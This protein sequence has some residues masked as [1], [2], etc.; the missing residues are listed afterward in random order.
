MSV[1]EWMQICIDQRNLKEKN[2]QLLLMQDIYLGA[3]R[4]I[5]W[6]GEA[7]DDSHLALKLLRRLADASEAA[8]VLL[9]DGLFN[10]KQHQVPED[11]TEFNQKL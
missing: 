7:R 10:I 11:I 9:E 5:I 3:Q 2:Q 8:Q 6:L 1:C 4:T